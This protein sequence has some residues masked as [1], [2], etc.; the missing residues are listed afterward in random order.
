M[1]ELNPIYWKAVNIQ[2]EV[3]SFVAARLFYFGDPQDVDPKDISVCFAI[4]S[5]EVLTY[6]HVL[7]LADILI[8]K[9]FVFVEKK[10]KKTKEVQSL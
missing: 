8:R 3:Y 5:I 1:W 2:F 4:G 6:S 10:T 9:K 7:S